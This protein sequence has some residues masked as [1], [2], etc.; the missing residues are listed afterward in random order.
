MAV[1]C[2]LKEAAKDT[3]CAAIEQADRAIARTVLHITHFGVFHYLQ[4]SPT[5]NPS[6]AL[7]EFFPTR[8]VRVRV[9]VGK[10]SRSAPKWLYGG[11]SCV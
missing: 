9:R 7:R 6:G 1:S 11:P 2:L 3:K 5:Y 8:R 10:N 4:E